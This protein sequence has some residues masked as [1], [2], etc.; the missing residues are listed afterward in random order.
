MQF[1][2]KPLG[3]LWRFLRFMNQALLSGYYAPLVSSAVCARR[4]SRC[5]ATVWA[6]LLRNPVNAKLNISEMTDWDNRGGKQQTEVCSSLA[7]LGEIDYNIVTAVY[8]LFSRSRHGCRQGGD[9]LNAGLPPLSPVAKQQVTSPR[10][11]N[12]RNSTS[13]VGCP[14]FK[15]N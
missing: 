1:S 12:N 7:A 8:V 4:S 6:G 5:T 13:N 15:M 2:V 11:G 10:V 14:L 9:S 3:G